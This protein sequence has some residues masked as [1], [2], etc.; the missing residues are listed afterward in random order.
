MLDFEYTLPTRIIFG[1]NKENMVGKEVKK[2]GGTKVLVHYGSNS[3]KKSGLLDRVCASLEAEK[4]SYILLGDVKPNPRLSK[5]REGID[6]ARKEDIDFILAVG[7]GSVIDS[8]KGIGYG[9][10]YDGDVWDFY[11]RKEKPVDCLPIGVILTIAASGSETSDGSVVTNEDGNLKKDVGSEYARP[12]FAILNP[13]LTYSLPEYQTECGTTDIIMHALERYFTTVTDVELIDGFL[14]SLMRTV[15]HN[16]RI[17]LEKPDDYAARAELMLSGSFCHNGMLTCGRKGDWAS[18]AIEH[19]LSGMFDIAHGAGLAAIWCSW[20]RYVMGVDIM[21]FAQFAVNVMGC[22]MD[23]QNPTKTAMEGIEAMRR[24][25][26]SINMPT[27]IAE[28]GIELSNQDIETMANKCT[29]NGTKTIG[30]FKQLNKADI[31]NIYLMA[32]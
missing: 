22:I 8:A 21:R 3:A 29:N 19:E 27:T 28:L 24:F 5:I 1:K 6:L 4:I 17:V 20:A 30:N 9:A 16:L 7:G 2:S 11:L 32:R 18:H 25:L 31:I 12:K 13:E 14:E 15:M 26:H 10:V 23:Y